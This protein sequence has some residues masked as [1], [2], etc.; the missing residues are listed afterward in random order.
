[1]RGTDASRSKDDSGILSKEL[2]KQ[3]ET[4]QEELFKSEGQRDELQ[5]KLDLIERQLE[6]SQGRETEL[7]VRDAMI[8][9]E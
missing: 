5:V 3:N 6:E 7:Q 1:M 8:D 9:A 2:K 4:L